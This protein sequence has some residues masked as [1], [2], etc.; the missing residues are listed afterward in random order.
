MSQKHPKSVEPFPQKT[1]SKPFWPFILI[2]FKKDIRINNLAIADFPQSVLLIALT[3]VGPGL[4]NLGRW[5][6][7]YVLRPLSPP[8][9]STS[10]PCASRS[11]IQEEVGLIYSSKNL[12]KKLEKYHP[13][14]C[15]TALL[16]L[17]KFV[18]TDLP[19]KC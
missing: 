4:R 2:I 8:K 10:M 6:S 3:V 9:L 15:M 19:S 12:I 18:L 17:I 14:S 13:L 7:L 5:N 11:K 16:T 1:R